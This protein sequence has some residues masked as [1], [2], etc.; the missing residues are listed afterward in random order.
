[1]SPQQLQQQQYAVLLL[2]TGA[3]SANLPVTNSLK[4]RVQQ[5]AEHCRKGGGGGWAAGAYVMAV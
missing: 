5:R 4:L 1:V 3:A 2:R